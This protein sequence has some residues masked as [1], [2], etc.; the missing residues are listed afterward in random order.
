MFY[1]ETIVFSGRVS[2]SERRKPI[3]PVKMSVTINPKR[4]KTKTFS[5]ETVKIV[6][7]INMAVNSLVPNPPNVMGINPA[8]FAMGNKRRK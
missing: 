5:S 6:E 2:V 4:E 7:N 1:K 3:K 8:V